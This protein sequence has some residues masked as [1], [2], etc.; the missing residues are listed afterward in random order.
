MI[1]VAFVDNKGQV[2]SIV[3]PASDTM[4]VDG[5]VYGDSVARHIP[6]DT[7]PDTFMIY[8]H[9]DFESNN[10]GTPK[11]PKPNEFSFW[12]DRGEWDVNLELVW[13]N[14]RAQRERKL[15]ESDWTQ[16]T[17]APLTP[18]QKSAWAA[19]RQELRN[20]PET[21]SSATHPDDVVWP[22]KPE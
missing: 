22:T 13:V 9:W 17:D 14:I 2:R 1:K 20:I 11:P 5:G 7:N 21:Y 6:Y 15:L 12:S 16:F 10:W 19:Y 3:T 8:Q 18:E 4:Y